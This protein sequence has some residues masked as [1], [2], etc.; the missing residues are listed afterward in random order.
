[1]SIPVERLTM[2]ALGPLRLLGASLRA[3]SSRR[4]PESAWRWD[5][6]KVML[7]GIHKLR[8]LGVESS[9]ISTQ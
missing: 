6:R 4:C 8:R 2:A 7:K 5:T 1:M 9:C 3:R